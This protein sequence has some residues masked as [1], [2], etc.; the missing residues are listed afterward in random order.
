[1]L[2]STGI[3]PPSVNNLN[4]D[5]LLNA[6]KNKNNSINL[7]QQPNPSSFSQPFQNPVQA[8]QLPI[9]GTIPQIQGSLQ[10]MQ[11]GVQQLQNSMQSIQAPIQGGMQTNQP[12]QNTQVPLPLVNGV[13]PNFTINKG[14]ANLSLNG[15]QDGSAYNFKQKEIPQLIPQSPAP[16]I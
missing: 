5:P 4:G 11:V 12:I 1:M 16:V 9:Q 3:N 7:Q 8:M 6:F 2:L 14:P 13:N 15:V 10:P